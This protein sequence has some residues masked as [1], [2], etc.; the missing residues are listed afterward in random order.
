MEITDLSRN[1]NS[2]SGTVKGQHW[3][4]MNDLEIWQCL[5]GIY[6]QN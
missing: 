4:E 3:L 6:I 1:G 2:V 5:R